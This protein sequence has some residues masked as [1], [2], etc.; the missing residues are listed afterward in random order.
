MYKEAISLEEKRANLL[1][2]I[3]RITRRL[4]TIQQALF[5]QET[6]PQPTPAPGFTR[7]PGRARRGELKAQILDAL[8]AAGTPGIRVQ[9]LATTLGVKAANL[10]SWFQ[11]STKRMSQ[12]KKV[13]A[14]RYR[15]EGSL[16]P[17]KEFP[18][19]EPG[20]NGRRGK[21]STRPLSRRGELAARI[22]QVLRDAGPEGVKVRE[23]AEKLGVKY[24]NLFIW[25]ATTGK[26]NK[27]IKKLGEAQYRLEE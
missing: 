12:I 24:K 8:A 25:F 20:R 11:T 5:D 23:I 16:P 9:D 4:S 26:K 14:A 19:R 21:L 18:I 1:S 15:L 2:E 7:R 27:A 10:H 13:G 22:L 6:T 3:E 17:P